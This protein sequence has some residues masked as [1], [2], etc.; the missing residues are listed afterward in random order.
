MDL[1]LASGLFKYEKALADR[2][3]ALSAFARQDAC[4]PA[5]PVTAQQD[6]PSTQHRIAPYSSLRRTAHEFRQTNWERRGL[7]EVR[8]PTRRGHA[9]R[10]PPAGRRAPARAG[11]DHNGGRVS[12]GRRSLSFPADLPIDHRAW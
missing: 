9:L 2:Q 12:A 11:G 7:H 1:R 6:T 10:R 3:R 4:R 8:D 5:L